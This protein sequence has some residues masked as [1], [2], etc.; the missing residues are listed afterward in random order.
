MDNLVKISSII[1]ENQEIFICLNEKTYT[2]E[3]FCQ[4]SQG[5]KVRVLP[6][7][8]AKLDEIYNVSD[9]KIK[10]NYFDEIGMQKKEDEYIDT[11]AIIYDKNR[12]QHTI[13]I[14][15]TPE[16]M[17][18]IYHIRIFL[19]NFCEKIIIEQNFGDYFKIDLFKDLIIKFD[20]YYHYDYYDFESDFIAFKDDTFYEEAFS[21]ELLHCLTHRNSKDKKKIGFEIANKITDNNYNNNFT[22]INEGATDFYSYSE[23]ESSYPELKYFYKILTN[24]VGKEKCKYYYANSKSTEFIMDLSDKTSASYREIVICLSSLDVLNS[25]LLEYRRASLDKASKIKLQS[26]VNNNFNNI[27]RLYFNYLLKYNPSEI[28]NISFDD[29]VY[30]SDRSYI[31]DNKNFYNEKQLKDTFDNMKNV[32]LKKL[33]RIEKLKK[34]NNINKTDNIM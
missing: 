12:N 14:K 8:K 16:M 17:E 13:N 6:E 26:M 9:G 4:N 1:F 23:K 32:M 7:T 3:F 33:E 2:Y 21:H 24:I 10:G 15:V 11:T 22:G 25:S 29:F 20:T 30:K 34:Q 5:K 19:K 28:K 31:K 18:Y 27:C